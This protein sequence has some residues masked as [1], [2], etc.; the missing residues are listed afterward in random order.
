MIQELFNALLLVP[1]RDVAEI[2][3]DTVGILCVTFME[4]EKIVLAWIS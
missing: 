3:T 2:F 1:T 4:E